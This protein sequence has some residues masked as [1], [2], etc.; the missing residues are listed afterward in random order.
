MD[1]MDFTQSVTR[2]RVMEKKLLDSVTIDKLVDA[3]DLDDVL[4][5]LQ[6]TEYADAISK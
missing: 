3:K 2:I 4:R 1:R 6:D 5:I